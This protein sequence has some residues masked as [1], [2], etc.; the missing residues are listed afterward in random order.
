MAEPLVWIPYCKDTRIPV[1]VQGGGRGARPQ[2]IF[3]VFRRG[4]KLLEPT[5]SEPKK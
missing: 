1:V 4:E 3:A 5:K 2:A